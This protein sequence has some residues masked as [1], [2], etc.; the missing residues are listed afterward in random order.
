[1][2][3]ETNWEQIDEMDDTTHLHIIIYDPVH[4]DSIYH[5]GNPGR[6]IHS[7]CGDYVLYSYCMEITSRVP[8]SPLRAC[9]AAPCR[10]P[11]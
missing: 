7:I 2:R 4:G 5:L 6:G 9:G 10:A 1:M 11:I 8:T 3:Y